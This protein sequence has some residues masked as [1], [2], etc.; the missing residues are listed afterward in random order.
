MPFAAFIGSFFGA[1]LFS[2]LQWFGLKYQGGF[3]EDG[4]MYR[5]ILPIVSSGLFGWLYV[6]IACRVAP[7]GKVVAGTVMVTIL[8]IVFFVLMAFHWMMPKFSIGESLQFT[9]AAAA[10]LVS[11]V[12]TLVHIH[13]EHSVGRSS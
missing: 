12:V 4:W 8:F 11:A 13:A 3:S 2:L 9:V 5:Y 6:W 7:W 10:A 1:S